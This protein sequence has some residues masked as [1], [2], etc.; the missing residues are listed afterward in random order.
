MRLVEALVK[1]Y[2]FV[3]LRD[4]LRL[5]RELQEQFW[6]SLYPEIEDGDV[7]LRVGPLEWLNDKVPVSVRQVPVVGG[8]EPYSWLHWQESRTVGNL[9]RQNQAAFEAALADGKIT[10]E[11]FDKAVAAT[12]RAYYETLFADLEQSWD[13][14]AQ[15]DHM[16]EEKFGRDA[17]SLRNLKNA[18]EDGRTLLEGIVKRK[19]ELEPDAPLM[20]EI[21]E[22]PG[23][24]ATMAAA[25]LSVTSGATATGN[26]R[27]QPQDRADAL[28]RLAAVAEYFRQ[29]EPHSP[30]AH[31][32]QR[33]VHWG[34]LSLEDWLR[35]VIKDSSVLSY[36]LQDTLGLN[37]ENSS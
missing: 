16:V 17:P 18:I 26:L 19:R 8:M 24:R 29:H 4:G 9:G 35:E 21:P 30:I 32:V 7:G 31:L 23:D 36:V 22:V 12:S 33:A 3:G 11:Q 6:D 13:E 10:D 25:A 20:V 5:L 1:Q 34:D 27:L 15:L 14:Y 28:R 37:E 2:G